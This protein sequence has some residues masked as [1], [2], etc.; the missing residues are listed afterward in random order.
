MAKSRKAGHETALIT[1]ASSGIGEAL[2]RRFARGG[3]D[4]VLVARSA[5]KLAVL[6]KHLAA[7]HKVKVTVV[8]ADLCRPGAAHTLATRMRRA[9]RAIDVLVNCA[10]VMQHGAFVAQAPAR[11]QQLIDLNVSALTA[12][13]AHFLPAMVARGR[14]RILNVASIAAFQPVPS[15]ATY[16]A[17][18]AYV[19]SLS[20]ALAQ[21]LEGT[22]VTV[23]ALCPG[24][25]ATPMLAAATAAS[26][27]LAQ[28][29]GIVISDVEDVANAGYQAC[30]NGDVIV[31]PGVLNQAA[32]LAGRVAPKWLLRSISG[33]I[34]RW[35]A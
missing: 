19:L 13:L 14:G 28:L 25:T 18:K 17:T 11:H 4:L 35:G 12:M 30:I 21:E 9:R 3:F 26:P 7:T 2:A 33:A 34:G 22:G 31:V 5:D 20:E 16:A 10:G 1:G 6:A 27:G 29:P 15:L 8:P 23:T 24:I 32:I